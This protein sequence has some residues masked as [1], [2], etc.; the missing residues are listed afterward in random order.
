MCD[1]LQYGNMIEEGTELI[2][3]HL[4]DRRM[5]SLSWVLKEAN[6]L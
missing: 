5:W 3:E 1:Y 4:Q 6:K 2:M